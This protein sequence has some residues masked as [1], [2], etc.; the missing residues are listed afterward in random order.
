M[1]SCFPDRPVTTNAVVATCVVFVPNDAV[2]ANGVPVNVGLAN[3][4][5]SSRALCNPDVF[6]IVRSPL[7]IVS[8]FPESPFATNSVVATCV[9]FVPDAAVGAVGT[10]VKVGFAN[11]AFVAIE[12]VTV[13]AKF[14]SSSNAAASSFKVSSVPGAESTKLLIVVFTKLVVAI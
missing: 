10:P 6:A 11:G 8:C 3:G 4:A 7:A 13:F 14:G 1:V 12:L 9:V 5:F 2:G